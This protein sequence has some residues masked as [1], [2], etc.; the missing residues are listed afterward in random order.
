M[1]ETR[2]APPPPHLPAA[3]G[4]IPE[5]PNRRHKSDAMQQWGQSAGIQLDTTPQH[6]SQ[7]LEQADP[8]RR[9]HPD[10][11]SP[12]AIAA[13]HRFYAADWAFLELAQQLLGGVAEA[14]PHGAQP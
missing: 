5:R 14:A 13:L 12:E 6:V 2:E 9:L 1:V 10:Q 11:L 3:A 4:L 7:D 8:W